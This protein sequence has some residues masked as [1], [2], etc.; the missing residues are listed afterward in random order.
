MEFQS[1]SVECNDSTDKVKV[2][3]N[4]I[5][6]WWC[7]CCCFLKQQCNSS[8][9]VHNALKKSVL[10]RKKRFWKFFGISGIRTHR[11]PVLVNLLSKFKSEMLEN[12]ALRVVCIQIGALVPIYF[13]RIKLNSL[14]RPHNKG[15]SH[16]IGPQSEPIGSL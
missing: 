4:V 6:W 8:I 11:P 7:C 12:H 1:T 2:F 14:Q 5:C 16:D 9:A 10:K 13:Y 15:A 3:P